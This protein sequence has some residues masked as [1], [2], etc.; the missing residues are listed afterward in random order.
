MAYWR[1][2]L[3][4][5][6][7][8]PGVLT[9]QGLGLQDFS[10]AG[11]DEFLSES[12]DIFD[13]A[14][15]TYHADRSG[16]AD[17]TDAIQRAIDDAALAGGGIVTLP[18]GIFRVRVKKGR[19]A[20]L[21][22]HGRNVTLRGAGSDKTTILCETN[23]MREKSVIQVGERPAFFYAQNS[24]RDNKLT[25]SARTYA[26]D[27]RVIDSGD[28]KP[29]D[30]IV[31]RTDLTKSYIRAHGMTGRWKPSPK[32]GPCAIRKVVSVSNGVIGFDI[33]LRMNFLTRDNAR[34]SL[35]TKAAEHCGI[36]GLSIHSA[37][38]PTSYTKRGMGANDY[39]KRASGAYRIHSASLVKFVQAIDCRA[40]DVCSASIPGCKYHMP[41]RGFVITESC[42]SITLDDCYAAYPQYTGGGG[43]GYGFTICGS[44]CLLR[45]C[46]AVRTR[47]NFSIK[48]AGASGNVLLRFES[49]RGKLVC[50]FHMHLSPANL[51]DCAI[52]HKDRID[53]I[54]RY[55]SDHGLTTTESVIWNTRG[56]GYRSDGKYAV[57]SRQYGNGYVIGTRGD[58]NVRTTPCK[59][60]GMATAPAD[61]VEGVGAGEG[62]IP[63][64]LYEDQ[65]R[66]RKK[67]ENATESTNV[68]SLEKVLREWSNIDGLSISIKYDEEA[69]QDGE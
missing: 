55:S 11:C 46:K 33:P 7:W 40:I 69:A 4:K 50:D 18:D 25:E 27:I 36:E 57:D 5:E 61:Y 44:E 39:L 17:S 26:K 42:R 9:E 24:K 62:L 15:E 51:I 34:I 10:Y 37:R 43:N 41:S 52:L 1:S 8:E 68:F 47:H 45:D 6:D 54:P 31:L 49:V 22:I 19:D 63:Q 23:S 14:S 16:K 58:G 53:A 3:Y 67:K 32:D 21:L 12:L 64:S 13:A 60:H 56:D 28:Y 48:G 29:G 66:R 2:A 59:V 65:L 30:V 20:A 38:L 35:F